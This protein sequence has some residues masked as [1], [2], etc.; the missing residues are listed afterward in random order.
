MSS[1]EDYAARSHKRK[2]YSTPDTVPEAWRRG[3]VKKIVTYDEA[4]VDYGL[5]SEDEAELAEQTEADLGN[6]HEID[7]VLTHARDEDHLTDER[8]IP[9]TNLASQLSRQSADRSVIT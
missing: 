4:Q 8:D 3:A 5:E 2:V 7:L 6:G 1:D 9:Q